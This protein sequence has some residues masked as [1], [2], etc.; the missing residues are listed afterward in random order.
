MSH[1]AHTPP[2]KASLSSRPKVSNL[3][4]LALAAA[5]CSRAPKSSRS[6]PST[7]QGCP[8]RLTDP[9]VATVTGLRGR[10]GSSPYPYL[11][12]VETTESAKSIKG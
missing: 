1:G 9:P 3:S 12:A 8:Y 10:K 4:D 5:N 11:R 2:R 7:H 6:S